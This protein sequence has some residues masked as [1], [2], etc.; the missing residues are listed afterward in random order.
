MITKNNIERLDKLVAKYAMQDFQ[1]V[2]TTKNGTIRKR[3]VPYSLSPLTN[4]AREMLIL[5][6]KEDIT[7]EEE[8]IVKAYLLKA[9]MTEIED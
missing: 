2:N 6:R 4:E 7:K 9:K 8:E 1:R 5:A 3:H